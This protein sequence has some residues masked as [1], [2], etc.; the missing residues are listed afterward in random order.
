M[1]GRPKRIKKFAFTSVWVYNRLR[2]DGALLH[3]SIS[4]VALTG[5]TDDD[6]DYDNYNDNDNDNDNDNK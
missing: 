3:L 5:N 1:D 4:V 2:M 6:D